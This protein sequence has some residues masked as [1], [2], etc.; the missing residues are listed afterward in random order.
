VVHGGAVTPDTGVV[1]AVTAASYI[2][3]GLSC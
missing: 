2:E 1:P 3:L